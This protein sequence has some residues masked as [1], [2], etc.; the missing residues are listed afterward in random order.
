L[1]DY[2]RALVA[3][4]R[5]PEGIKA[6]KDAEAEL[7]AL[8]RMRPRYLRIATEQIDVIREQLAKVPQ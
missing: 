1:R 6:L 8:S 2:G 7:S 3:C 5:K 4:D